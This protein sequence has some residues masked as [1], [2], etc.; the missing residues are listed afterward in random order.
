M[1]LDTEKMKATIQS[2][3]TRLDDQKEE[4]QKEISKLEDDKTKLHAQFEAVE[5]IEKIAGDFVNGSGSPSDEF[6]QFS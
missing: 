6:M 4:L 1:N 3:V 5:G 2:E